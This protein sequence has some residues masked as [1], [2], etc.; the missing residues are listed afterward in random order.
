MGNNLRDIEYIDARSR[1]SKRIV[2]K[3][4]IVVG[5]SGKT[6]AEVRDRLI[7]DFR[8]N[9]VGDILPL[10]NRSSFY[11]IDGTIIQQTFPITKYSPPYSLRL[12]TENEKGSTLPKLEKIAGKVGLPVPSELIPGISYYD[13]SHSNQK[14][15]VKP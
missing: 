10:T 11:L 14:E 5:I 9:T 15:T 12:V 4:T 2:S 6:L 3:D 1:D 13:L 7:G 8:D